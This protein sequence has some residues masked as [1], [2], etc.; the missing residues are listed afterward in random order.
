MLR[1]M[2]ALQWGEPFTRKPYFALVCKTVSYTLY[3]LIR[4][5]RLLISSSIFMHTW[6]N[7]CSFD[8]K[9]MLRSH[10]PYI[11]TFTFTFMHLADAFIQSDLHCIQNIY[12]YICVYICMC[13]YICVYICV[14]LVVYFFVKKKKTI[15]TQFSKILF[16]SFCFCFLL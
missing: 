12:V 10:T 14:C 11:F 4:Q 7:D 3:S 2:A 6:L 15:L 8:I 16:F 9:V 13:M 5:L 1:A